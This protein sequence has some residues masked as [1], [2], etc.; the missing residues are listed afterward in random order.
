MGEGPTH[1]KIKAAHS[2]VNLMGF[3]GGG[4]A[5]LTNHV[6]NNTPLQGGPLDFANNTIAGMGVGDIT[7]SDGAA[8]QT[9]P[10][11]GIPN[12]EVL[13]FQPL[14]TA[15]SWQTGASVTQAVEKIA[16]TV[17]PAG[18]QSITCSFAA[19]DQVDCAKFY[20][21]LNATKPAATHIFHMYINGIT[22]ATYQYQWEEVEG[23]GTRTSGYAS[24]T[25]ELQVVHNWASLSN[26]V[27]FDVVLNADS[28]LIQYSTLGMANSDYKTCVGINTT[29]AQTSLTEIRFDCDNPPNNFGAGTTLSVY[30]V[31]L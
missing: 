20:G 28:E 8:L 16:S 7:F 23:A 27:T 2:G 25:T 13:T 29:A 21:V 30:K 3:G 14:A 4:G 26:I 12:N 24:A 9:L 17:L 22:T 15:P 11:P 5:Q 6:H 31:N 19:V 10:A 18:G 1:W